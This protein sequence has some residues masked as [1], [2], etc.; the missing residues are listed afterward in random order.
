MHWFLADL[1]SRGLW[2]K[3]WL[4]VIQWGHQDHFIGQDF[5]W[6]C[7]R[8]GR[9]G[10]S[11]SKVYLI[12]CLEIFKFQEF[13]VASLPTMPSSFSRS[14]VPS[15]CKFGNLGH[16][17]DG[18]FYVVHYSRQVS[19]T[20]LPHQTCCLLSKQAQET[21]QHLLIFLKVVAFPEE[22]SQKA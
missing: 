16:P 20:R 1:F 22:C 4:T 2:D 8:L 6:I 3:C 21:I 17:Y 11:D 12:A 15:G 9:M 13:T 18:E 10:Q 14:G 5:G 19:Q 7:P